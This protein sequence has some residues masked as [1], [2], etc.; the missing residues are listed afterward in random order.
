MLYSFAG[1]IVDIKFKN[2]FGE[3]YC[4]R[5]LYKGAQEPDFSVEV[6]EQML[7]QERQYDL[8][9]SSEELLECIAAYREICNLAFQY[10]CIFMHCSAIAYHNNGILFTAPSGTGKSTHSAL[11]VKHFGK[12]VT[13][14]ND[15]KPLLR[16]Q[17]GNIFVC[18]TPWDGKHHRSTNIMVP[19][20]AVVVLSQG[21][22]NAIRP[23]SR[24][25]AL[26]HLLN[27][28]I[29]PDNPE[30]MNTVLNIVEKMIKSIPVYHLTCNISDE[31]VMT[32]FDAIKENFNE[33]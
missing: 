26:Y 28:T 6:N 2:P 14:V 10:D 32:V 5:Y 13:V 31:A 30:Q 29:R 1:L 4:E 8:Y 9:D 27:Q 33:D 19:V 15:D 20:K 3:K 17:N 25:E 7:E 24:Q 23:A 12:D 22:E 16:E 21:E 18:G 11:W